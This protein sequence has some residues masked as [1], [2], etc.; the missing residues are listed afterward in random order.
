MWYCIMGLVGIDSFQ[1]GPSVYVLSRDAGSGYP[2][3][4]QR[5]KLEDL[6]SQHFRV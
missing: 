3:A 4:S 6:G 1:Q 2:L 5:D